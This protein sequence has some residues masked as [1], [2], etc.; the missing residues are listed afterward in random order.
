MLSRQEL[1]MQAEEAEYDS[2][3][4]AILVKKTDDA[5]GVLPRRVEGDR[6]ISVMPMKLQLSKGKT[7]LRIEWTTHPQGNIELPVKKVL[8]A[9]STATWESKMCEPKNGPSRT[10]CHVNEKAHG[11]LPMMEKSEQDIPAIPVRIKLSDD[12]DRLRLDWP[13]ALDGY[14]EIPVIPIL[15]SLERYEE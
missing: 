15:E 8:H 9:I 10:I 1:A 13:H 5:R 6:N 14:V 11:R 12:E 4:K 3:D 7:H 2:N